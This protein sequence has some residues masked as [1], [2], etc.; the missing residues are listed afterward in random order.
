VENELSA[1][2]SDHRFIHTKTE[3]N[4][5]LKVLGRLVLEVW[6]KGSVHCYSSFVWRVPE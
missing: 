2:V 5:F 3:E 4:S 1:T 6:E